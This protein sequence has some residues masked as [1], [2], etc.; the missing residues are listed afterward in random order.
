MSLVGAVKSL[1]AFLRV[2]NHGDYARTRCCAWLITAIFAVTIV[3]VNLGPLDFLLARETREPLPL[4]EI[5]LCEVGMRISRCSRPL[6][7]VMQNNVPWAGTPATLRLSAAET[8]A[9]TAIR[10]TKRISFIVASVGKIIS[11]P[12][13]LSL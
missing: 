8:N 11:P 5:G 2:I 13:G 3:I 1:R 7:A 12:P 4:I 10:R 9:R 6:R